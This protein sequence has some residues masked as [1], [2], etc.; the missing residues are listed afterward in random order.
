MIEGDGCD[1]PQRAAFAAVLRGLR[2][3]CPACG[4]GRLFA[5]YLRVRDACGTCGET[6]HHQRADDAPAYFT[7]FI[8][9]HL[10]VAGVLYLERAMAPPT[11]V[12]AAIW[13]PL[14]LALSVTLLPRIKGAL[15]G[16]QWALGM[17]GF[18]Q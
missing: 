2:Q 13:L 14:T 11:W 18:A 15:V 17:H 5:G 12:H 8:V 7:I 9:G 4:R 6:L 10:M 1:R 16:L 3:R